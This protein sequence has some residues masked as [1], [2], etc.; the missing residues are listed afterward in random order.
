MQEIK[1]K[2]I[3]ALDLSTLYEAERLV[4]K[5]YPAGIKKFK[6]GNQLFTA[7]GPDAVK[8]VGRK[9]GLVFLD[10]K[11]HDIPNTV[12]SGV[13]SGTGI[14]CEMISIKAEVNNN[15]SPSVTWP[16]FMMTVHIDLPGSKEMLIKAVEGAEQKAKEMKRDK[17]YILGVTVLTSDNYGLDSSEIVLQKAKLAQE[18]GLD[19]VVCSVHEVAA[20]R[21]AC[22]KDFIIVTP[23]IRPKGASTHDQKRTATAREA[24]KA[25]SDFLVIGRPILEAKDPIFVV[26]NILKELEEKK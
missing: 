4:D 26:D 21:E 3:V 16:V 1:D 14:T 8:M 5:L 23:G 19:G 24:I 17:P 7:C 25:G 9:G 15:V 22:G 11:F 18:A 10:L 13:V 20:V 6:V 12:F 2:L